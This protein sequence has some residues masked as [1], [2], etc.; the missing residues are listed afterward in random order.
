MNAKIAVLPESDTRP[1]SVFVGVKNVE[2]RDA[3]LDS[4]E[5]M[6]EEPRKMAIGRKT[7]VF[8]KFI[9]EFVFGIFI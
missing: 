4:V 3:F 1:S 7:S 2:G 5:E 6:T 8:I 9:V